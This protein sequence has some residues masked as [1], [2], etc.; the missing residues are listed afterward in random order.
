VTLTVSPTT[1]LIAVALIV[2][3]TGA[4][5]ASAASVALTSPPDGATI[6]TTGKTTSVMISWTADTTGCDTSLVTAEPKISGP[7]PVAGQAITGSP[8]SGA[9]MLTFINSR[10]KR[11]YSWYVSMQCPGV[12]EIRSETRRFTIQGANPEPRLGGAYKVLWGRSAQT[13]KFTPLCGRGACRTRVKIPGV[14]S[15]ILTY[16]AKK[17]LYT[18]RIGGRKGSRAGICTDTETGKRFFNAYRGWFQ[19]SLRVRSTQVSGIHTQASQLVG[20]MTGRYV[21]TARGKRLSC[22]AFRANDP[23]RASKK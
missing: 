18:A 17:G 20:R 5:Q 13:W 2:G 14:P 12:G 15:F 8:P 22:P 9:N 11:K 19:L 21:P 4:T 1:L 10:P 23:V 7:I 16:R 6:P 3:L